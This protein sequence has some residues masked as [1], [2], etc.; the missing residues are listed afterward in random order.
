MLH[1]ADGIAFGVDVGSS[2]SLSGPS[3]A[4]EK[5]GPQPRKRTSLAPAN[6]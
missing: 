2:L 5:V 1:L 4:M 6:S 3:M